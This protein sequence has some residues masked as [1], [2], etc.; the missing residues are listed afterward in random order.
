MPSRVADTYRRFAE[1]EANGVSPTYFEWAMS[2]SG[3]DEILALIERLPRIKTQPNLVFAAARSLGAPVGPYAPFRDWLIS[4]WE[5]VVPVILDRATQTNEAARCAVLL[6]LLAQMEGPLSL[7]EAGASAGLVLYPDRYSYDYDTESRRISLDPASG[8]SP[9]RIPCRIDAASVPGRVPE[10]VWRAG[11][12]LHPIDVTDATELAW[13]ET[14]VWPEHDERRAR[15]RAA[16]RIVAAEP[17]HLV[18]GD[19]IDA[20]PRLV[21][22]APEGTR[23]V[24]FHS[25]VLVYLE[26]ERRARFAELMASLPDV[27][28]ISNEG[29]GVFPHITD[30]VSRDIRGRTIVSLDGEPVALAG[31]HGQSFERL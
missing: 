20:I 17:P 24:V 22:A 5:D 18:A 31:P 13:L 8:S 6:P 12:D 4:R 16:A 19:I 30:R 10:V 15:L 2:I 23:I 28:W 25:A 9:V 3:D 27:T 1:L 26:P 14:L 7:I 11:A 21:A 29:A